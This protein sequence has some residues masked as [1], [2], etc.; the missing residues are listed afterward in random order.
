LQLDP[1]LSLS[2]N[3]FSEGAVF[4]HSHDALCF[5]VNFSV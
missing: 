1:D 4:A 2:A 5:R 3:R